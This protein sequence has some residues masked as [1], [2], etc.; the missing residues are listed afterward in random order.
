M[1]DKRDLDALRK[2]AGEGQASLMPGV[3]LSSW[4]D[5][6]KYLGKSVRTVERWEQVY[7][8]PV[9]HRANKLVAAFPAE[10]DQWLR[11]WKQRK[12]PVLREFVEEIK[13]MLDETDTR[14]KMKKLTEK[15]IQIMQK[16]IAAFEDNMAARAK[17]NLDDADSFF[18]LMNLNMEIFEMETKFHGGKLDAIKARLGVL[19]LMNE[20]MVEYPRGL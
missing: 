16:T 14:G 15:E 2:W 7:G 5:I 13:T 8:L 20:S 12:A 10:L 3:V 4:K 6:A 9:F 17:Y 11:T 18:M 1:S 19:M